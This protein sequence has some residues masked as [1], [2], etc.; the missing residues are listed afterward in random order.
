M[1]PILAAY[2]GFLFAMPQYRHYAFESDARDIIRFELRD[3]D[4]M[5]EK[6]YQKALETGI[7]IPRHAIVVTHDWSGNY[8]ATVAWSETVDV[9]GFY[10]KQYDFKVEVT[11]KGITR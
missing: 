2:I 3:P 1:V 11:S 9:F 7:V 5:Q 8:M 4:A 6:L 10:S